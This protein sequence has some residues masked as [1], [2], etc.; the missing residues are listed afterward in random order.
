MILACRLIDIE[1]NLED[2]VA[3]VV[4]QKVVEGAHV[5]VT[6]AQRRIR[7]FREPNFLEIRKLSELVQRRFTGTKRRAMIRPY[8]TD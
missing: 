7:V 8:R 5:A 6:T 4:L 3:E 2:L 1:E